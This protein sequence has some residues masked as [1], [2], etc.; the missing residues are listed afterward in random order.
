MGIIYLYF[1]YTNLYTI[2]YLPFF[3][4]FFIMFLASIAKNFLLGFFY[5]RKC[6]FLIL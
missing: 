1:L 3:G 5:E 4:N 2:L 6:F